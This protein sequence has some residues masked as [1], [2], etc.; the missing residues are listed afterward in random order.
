MGFFDGTAAFSV[1]ILN[2]YPVLRQ[3]GTTF[4]T[5]VTIQFYCVSLINPMHIISPINNALFSL[6]EDRHAGHSLPY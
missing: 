1:R 6:S 5:P 4:I 3:K 2:S